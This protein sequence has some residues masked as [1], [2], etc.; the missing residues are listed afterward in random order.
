MDL[1]QH[2][3]HLIQVEQHI[4]ASETRVA[5]QANLVEWMSKDGQDTK[6]AR[7][8]LQVFEQTLDHMRVRRHLIL[9]AIARKSTPPRT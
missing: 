3:E 4:A 8:L 9:D 6:L 2:H 5:D 7:Q 1:Q